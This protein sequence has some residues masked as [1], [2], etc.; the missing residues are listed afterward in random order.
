MDVA[1]STPT[2]V[3]TPLL[4]VSPLPASARRLD[5]DG[6]GSSIPPLY[7]PIYAVRI[8]RV[9]ELGGMVA[10][11]ALYA[12][13]DVREWVAERDGPL[14]FVSH[15]WT[16]FSEPDPTGTQFALLQGVLRNALR[17]RLES[18]VGAPFAT[19]DDA[20]GG[21]FGAL[22]SAVNDPRGAWIW[23]DYWSIPQH[24]SPDVKMLGIQSI[25]A[26]IEA[27]TCMLCLV[28][29][30]AHRDTHEWCDAA[31]YASRI[32]TPAQV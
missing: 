24:A 2:A 17:G 21:V 11:E 7:Y 12:A 31:S 3:E 13:G 23:L 30:V 5:A 18:V 16:A 8:E 29:R 4:S 26:F 14:I 20:D 9:L 32:C 15:Q 1:V 19:V 27:S 22:L 25:P 10:H 6:D 28:P